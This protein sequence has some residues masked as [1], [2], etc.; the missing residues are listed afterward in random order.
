MFTETMFITLATSIDKA[1]RQGN[2]SWE[3]INNIFHEHAFDKRYKVYFGNCTND[4]HGIWYVGKPDR[5]GHKCYLEFQNDKIYLYAYDLGKK[6]S[7]VLNIKR[8]KSILSRRENGDNIQVKNV[9]VKFF[10]KSFGLNDILENEKIVEKQ[11]NGMIVEGEYHNEFVA[12]QRM[13]S[14]GANCTVLEPQAIREKII[15]KLKNM[16]KNYNG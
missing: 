1:K 6:E 9:C 5:N 10:L 12:V 8:I 11:E 7:V 2:V 16:R 4:M 14:F 15:E 13:L 3:N